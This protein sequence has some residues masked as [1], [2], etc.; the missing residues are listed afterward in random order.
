MSSCD[1]ST[2]RLVRAR[3]PHTCECHRRRLDRCRSIYH[4]TPCRI[5]V[6]EVHEV[7]SGIF[8]GEP[9]RVRYCLFHAAAM[10]VWWHRQNPWPSE[11]IDPSELADELECGSRD[12][13]LKLLH[14]VRSELRKYGEK[15]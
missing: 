9:Y 6:G 7:Q 13:W 2:T 11:G 4:N 15:K 12:E 5:A 8:E 10:S 3:K 14:E 1:C